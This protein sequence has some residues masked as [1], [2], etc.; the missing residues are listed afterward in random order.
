M[1]HIPANKNRAAPAGQ[2]V[3]D[4]REPSKLPARD[5]LFANH[6]TV[7]ILTALSQFAKNWLAEHLPAHAMRWG[8]G[9]V[10]EP[11]YAL[12]ILNGILDAGLTVRT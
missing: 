10:I 4:P 9:V 12:P 11:R 5:F 8:G 2:V 3:S 7:T 6:G 1:F